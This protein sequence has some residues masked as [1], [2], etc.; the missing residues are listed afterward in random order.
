[1]SYPRF[2]GTLAFLTGYGSAGLHCRP[3]LYAGIFAEDLH[4]DGDQDDTEELTDNGDA[5][6]PQQLL[7]KIQG[8][9]ADIDDN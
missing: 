4:G 9:Q 8:A 3:D 7:D 2:T 5:G 1:M 6:R